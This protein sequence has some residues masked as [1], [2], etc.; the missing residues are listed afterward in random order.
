MAYILIVVTLIVAALVIF[1]YVFLHPLYLNPLGRIPGPKLYA[2]TRWRLAY[3]DWKGTRTRTIHQ[4]HLKHGPVVRVG[5]NEVSFNSLTALRTIYG[6]GSRF[7]RTTFYRMF[8]AYGEQNL[9]TFHSTKEHGDRKKLLSHA[10]AKSVVLKEPTSLM[11]EDKTREYIRLIESEPDNISEIFTTLHYYSLDNITDFI[12]GE[13]GSTSAMKGIKLHR[14]LIDDIM[15]PSRRR[16]SWFWVHFPAFT[17]WL[18]TR[19]SFLGQL[20]RPILPMQRPT[21]YTGIRQYAFDAVQKFV[22]SHK[23]GT[24]SHLDGMAYSQSSMEIKMFIAP[25]LKIYMKILTRNRN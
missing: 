23:D 16:L 20:V 24:H 9:F 15:H 22:A 1:E 19:T 18:Y 12:Y 10:Y 2:L 6:P 5:P 3:E 17:K 21:T 11:V 7:G 14:A 25:L 8:D 13:Y 4:L